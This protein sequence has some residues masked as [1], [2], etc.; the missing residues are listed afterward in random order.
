V[1]YLNRPTFFG[2]GVPA[3]IWLKEKSGDIVLFV[4]VGIVLGV[5][6]GFVLDKLRGATPPT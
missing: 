5:V 6:A 1:A 3:D 2:E 4:F